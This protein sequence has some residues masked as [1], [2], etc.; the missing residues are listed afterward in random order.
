MMD[1]PKSASNE[2]FETKGLLDPPVAAMTLRSAGFAP[3]MRLLGERT[4]T[5]K[6]ELP[7]AD[8]PSGVVPMK[9]PW[10]EWPPDA[11]PPVASIEI[12]GFVNRLITRP[13]IVQ[14]FVKMVRPFA[15]DPIRLPSISMRRTALSP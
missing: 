5:P 12:P 7:A 2:R 4:K 3:P 15:N 8:I 14:A 13:L 6:P 9:L 1:A 11:P 10:I